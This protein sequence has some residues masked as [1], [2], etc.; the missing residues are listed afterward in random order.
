MDAKATL[1]TK[2][3]TLPKPSAKPSLKSMDAK[4]TLLT[5]KRTLPKPSAKPSL[6]SM[7]AKATLLTKKRTL[8]KSSAKSSPKSFLISGSPWKN[9][10][11]FALDVGS[12]E[13]A[14]D[15]VKRL[16]DHMGYFKVGPQLF[17]SAGAKIIE[18]INSVGGK[19]FLDLKLHDIPQTIKKTVMEITKLNVAMFTIHALGGK[20]MLSYAR[21]GVEEG[22]AKGRME[23]GCAK[24]NIESSARPKILGVSLLTSMDEVALKNELKINLPMQE[25][26]LHLAKLAQSCELDG[27]VCSP[28][29][30]RAV[31]ERA[32]EFYLVTPGI[33]EELG[34]K[35][36]QKRALG[37]REAIASG[38]DL[39][40][41]GRPIRTAK[42]PLA[43]VE[44][45][46]KKLAQ[47]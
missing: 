9:K 19:V 45:I 1:L 20:K 8:P 10:L 26:V 15:W 3:R 2:E 11:C 22:Y 36:D 35:N 23:E 43:V 44:G 27:L 14:W 31:R 25:Y 12:Y 33:R 46:K 4:A 21:E 13:E 17:V 37:A 42:N 38:S 29:E 7:D 5:K 34:E 6:K 30:V 41:I 40:V 18:K 24:E 39:L 47:N 32:R 28:H 16:K